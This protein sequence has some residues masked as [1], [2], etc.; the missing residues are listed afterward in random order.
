MDENDQSS[1]TV[2][3]THK[4]AY[5]SCVRLRVHPVLRCE[6]ATKKIRDFG[7]DDDKFIDLYF[8]W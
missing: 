7:S 2:S 4:H 3:M 1:G 6:S 8:K 5:L